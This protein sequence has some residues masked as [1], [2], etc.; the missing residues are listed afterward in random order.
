M[1]FVF[2]GKSNCG[3]CLH[4]AVKKGSADVCNLLIKSGAE[5]DAT[6]VCGKTPLGTAIKTSNLDLVKFLLNRGA[7]PN[8]GECLHHAVKEGRADICKLLIGFGAKLDARNANKDTP[9]H[10]AV[11]NNN[12][13]LVKFLLVKIQTTVVNPNCGR[14]RGRN[15]EEH[16][17]VILQ[18]KM[19]L[20]NAT[21]RKCKVLKRGER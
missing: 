4:L 2:W 20:D 18:E 21:L 8:C 19:D 12:L 16:E 3:E 14:K 7:N 1:V 5:L 15:A 13:E 11:R 10:V 17:T 9:L 6:N